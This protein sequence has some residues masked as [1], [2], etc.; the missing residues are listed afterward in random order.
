MSKPIA[1]AHVLT[2]RVGGTAK[3]RRVYEKHGHQM[4]II[5]AG[6][7]SAAMSLV[8]EAAS[9]ASGSAASSSSK[10]T[11]AEKRKKQH[12]DHADAVMRAADI[13]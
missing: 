10:L 5:P 13:F 1:Q 4:A 7:A 2:L 3:V 11:P 9:T 8:A 6:K 12:E